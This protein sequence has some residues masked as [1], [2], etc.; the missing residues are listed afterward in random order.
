MSKDAEER[1]EER[2][3]ADDE[4]FERFLVVKEELIDDYIQGQL[5]ESDR[6]RFERRFFNSSRRRQQVAFA[7]ALKQKLSDSSVK[8]LNQV[9]VTSRRQLWFSFWSPRALIWA[10]ATAVVVLIL[11]LG[12][13][14]SENW[15]LRTELSALRNEKSEQLRREQ[16]MQQQLA[17]LRAQASSDIAASSPTPTPLSSPRVSPRMPPVSIEPLPTIVLIP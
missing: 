17:K 10:T 2:Y 14:I 1:F 15:R 11:G 13:F 16:E 5:S 7:H 12:W 3:F 8:A 6:E 9:E 4:M